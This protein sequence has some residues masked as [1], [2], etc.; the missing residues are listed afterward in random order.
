VGLRGG[1]DRS[2]AR[3]H[4]VPF[5]AAYAAEV[6]R[7]RLD[8]GDPDGA[9]AALW[10]GTRGV[11][12]VGGDVK[13]LLAEA[14]IARPRLLR[15]ALRV[16]LRGG[17]VRQRLAATLTVLGASLGLWQ[18][19]SSIVAAARAGGLPRSASQRRETFWLSDP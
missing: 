2:D 1:H 15:L 9:V 10:L 8:G 17:G 16:A 14:V 7:A 6:A 5:T 19:R 13:F 18:T 11:P 4:L 3:E 12:H